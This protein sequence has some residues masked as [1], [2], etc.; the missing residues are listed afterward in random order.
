MHDTEAGGA[1]VPALHTADVVPTAALLV[2]LMPAG[3]ALHDDAPPIVAMYPF[4]QGNTAVRAV[5]GQ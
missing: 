3:H 4:G 1:Y 2:H 5:V